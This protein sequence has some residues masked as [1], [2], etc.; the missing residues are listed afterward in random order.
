[1]NRFC[2]LLAAVAV[3]VGCHVSQAAEIDAAFDG[4]AAA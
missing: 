2:Q 3:V 4:Q 1:M